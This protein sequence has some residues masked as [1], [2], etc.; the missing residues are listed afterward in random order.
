[1]IPDGVLD[2]NTLNTA[3]DFGRNKL[4]YAAN[5]GVL[6]IVQKLLDEV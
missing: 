6:A 2:N 1:M 5:N 3:D 4:R